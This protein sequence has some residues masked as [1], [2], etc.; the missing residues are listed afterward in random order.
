MSTT[1]TKDFTR[2]P[3]T[4]DELRAE[5]VRQSAEMQQTRERASELVERN[6]QLQSLYLLTD[7][8]QRAV[9][10]DDIYTAAL[11]AILSGLRCDRASILLYD[12][13]QVMRFVAW[14][15]LSEDYR[16]AA[17]GH[18]PWKPDDREPTPIGFGNIEDV[19][20]EPQLKS[21]I[22]LEGIRAAAFI[23]LVTDGRIIGK[24]MT[25]F[26]SLH[27][28]RDEEMSL[29]INI[30]RQLA[31]GLQRHRSLQALF[32]AQRQ[33]ALAGRRKDEFIAMLA[34]ELRNPLAPITNAIALLAREPS[35]SPLQQEARALIERQTGRL[36]RLVDDLLDVSRIT[37]GRVQLKR[38]HVT[39]DSIIERAIETARP[40]LERESH[41]LSVHAAP[42]A[43]WLYADPTRLE[44][45]LVNLLSNAA[46][47]TPPSG[48]IRVETTLDEETAILSVSDNGIGI[49][50]ELLP[51]IF[52]LF[53]QSERSLDRSRGGLG[54]GLSVVDGL[55]KM[56]GGKVEVT[57]KVGAG[58]RFV[59]RLPAVPAPAIATPGLVP[60][61]RREPNRPPSAHRLRILVVD[62]NVDAAE[63]LRMLLGANGH[64]IAIS[65]DGEAALEH[66]AVLLPEVVF[67][68]IGLPGLDGYEVAQRLRQMPA[69]AG[70]LIVAMT[71]YGQPD[72]LRRSL[73]A[74]FDR[75]LVKPVDPAAIEHLLD[76]VG[77]PDKA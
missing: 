66:A 27:E 24:F 49:D 16:R 4:I 54:V 76:Q 58:S 25:Y 29:S 63:S 9:T 38:A 37:S 45:V 31:A 73:E 2:V 72:D 34:H 33:L 74:G 57:S 3:P 77:K 51:E 23:P 11:D 53:T 60:A 21:R 64:R 12:H 68:D 70:T 55:V 32:D 19:E 18:S 48:E 50:A 22:R 39:L 52:E 71:G 20:L 56:H 8:L 30:A 26:D 10:V 7:R 75:H 17:E 35:A 1:G 41:R 62:D 13:S 40:L 6:R 44:Q 42:D 65:H 5:L 61:P 15:G 43:I 36:T 47:Y 28:F 67:L 46:K 14:R 69:L 59:V